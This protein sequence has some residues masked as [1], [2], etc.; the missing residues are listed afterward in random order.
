MTGQPHEHARPGQRMVV[1]AQTF[2]DIVES[3][4]DYMKRRR[5]GSPPGVSHFPISTDKIKV[6]N[7]TGGNRR[8][9]EVLEVDNVILIDEVDPENLWQSGI[10]PNGSHPFGILRHAVVEEDIEELQVSGACKALVNIIDI[11]HQFAR[12]VCGKHVLESSQGGPVRL[13]F[14]PEV[15]GEQECIVLIMG[16]DIPMFAEAYLAEN[17]CGDEP[18]VSVSDAILLPFCEEFT[19]PRVTNPRRHSGIIGSNVLLIRK[20]CRSTGGDCSSGGEEEWQV[21]DIYLRDVCVVI[22]GEDRTSCLVVA[23]LKTKQEYCPSHE[24]ILGCVWVDMIDCD[25]ELP[26]CDRTWVFTPDFACCGQGESTGSGGDGNSSMSI[27]VP[28]SSIGHAPGAVPGR[29]VKS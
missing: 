26:P 13:M 29:F 7:D 15:T 28:P 24:P 14:Q 10:T 12:V 1:S 3:K 6:Q 21:F 17:I 20:Q 27:S 2:N 8:L 25:E 19:P 16:T 5:I 23:G 22:G 18:T 4:N 11:T 9:G